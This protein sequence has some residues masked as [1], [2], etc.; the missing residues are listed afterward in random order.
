MLKPKKE[1]IGLN[2]YE[3]NLYPEK[4]DMKLDSNENYIGPSTAVLNA[5]RNIEP[6]QVSHYP[7]YG[8]LYDV[9]AHNFEIPSSN[10]VLTNG[11]DEGLYAVINTYISKEDTILT[12]KP[13]FTMPKIYAQ[14]IGAEYIEIP[15]KTKWVYPY[16][17]VLK[18]V[19]DK[20][21]MIL[22]TTPNNPTGDIVPLEQIVELLEKFPE[23]AIV[24]DETYSSF[25]GISNICLTQKYNNAV[26]IKSFSKDYGLAGLR[27]GCIVSDRVNIDNIKRILRPYNVNSVVVKAGVAALNDENYLDLTKNE[28]T[29]S[30]MLLSE[31]LINLGFKPY[32]SYANFLLVDFGGKCNLIYEKLK[33]NGIIVKN[34][35]KNES[36]KNCLR[37]TIPT[38][39]AVQRIINLI[40]SK[41]TLV[42]DM[43]GVLVDVSSSYYEA[44]KYTYKHFTGKELSTDDIINAKKLGGFNNVWDLTH[45]LIQQY[46]FNFSYTD[47]VDKFQKHYWN[48]GDGSINDECL[49][50]DISLLE[51]LAKKYN[52]AIFTGRPREEANYTL[53]KF[54]ISKYFQK[55]IT[56]T[57][58]PSDKQKKGC[59]GLRLIKKDL[60]TD[61]LIYFGDT[62][63]DAKCALSFGA[64][65]VGVL[66]PND[67]SPEMIKLLYDAGAKAVINS[68][69]DLYDILEKKSDEIVPN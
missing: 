10:I 22:I 32:L 17:D 30:K 26:I 51:D 66:P 56:M 25:A 39:S 1:L 38:F 47:I 53:N 46:G 58:L 23:K 62:V 3:T 52:L 20:V 31:E 34:F 67:K 16:D 9:L 43:D 61:E 8:I 42:F 49:L 45:H 59:E 60:I 18:S 50:I 65:G 33:S 37:I 35:I 63:D 44:I 27:F 68:I 28:I 69:N 12:V 36:L 5:I 41:D 6:E 13:S 19:T 54:G 14:T 24:I 57:D 7:Y 64:Y 11:A 40:K 29:R 15:Y 21:K 4:W 55:V 48:D 2:I